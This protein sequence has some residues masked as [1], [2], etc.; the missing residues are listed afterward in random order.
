AL[1]M[2]AFRANPS[3]IDPRI[4]MARG[5]P[6]QARAAQ[7]IR[8]KLKG[9]AIFED[10]EPRRLQDPISIRCASHVHGS[11]RAAID[12]AAPNVEVELNGAGDNPLVIGRD[13]E[14][15]SNGNFHT[16]AMAVAFDALALAMGQ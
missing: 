5:A 8:A 4:V 9:S 11:L 13:G 14:I 6:G 16:P 2:E 1:T 7:S 12:F 15:L 3:P 10:G